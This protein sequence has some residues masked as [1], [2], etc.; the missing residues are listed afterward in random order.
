MKFAIF[1]LNGG[2]T[3]LSITLKKLTDPNTKEADL[4]YDIKPI[5]KG[6]QSKNDSK[7]MDQLNVVNRGNINSVDII[8]KPNYNLAVYGDSKG[9]IHSRKI[10][11]QGGSQS[12][13]VTDSSITAVRNY[14][15]TAFFTSTT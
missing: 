12:W 4:F 14:V 3:E 15:S 2:F 11:Q 6:N 7:N 5:D 10:G 13:K 9:Q 8:R 1:G